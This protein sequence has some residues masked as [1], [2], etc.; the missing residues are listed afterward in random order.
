MTENAAKEAVSFKTFYCDGHVITSPNADLPNIV[1]P[2]AMS[3]MFS[4][5]PFP[6]ECRELQFSSNAYPWLGFVPS[7]PRWQG[8]LLGK[9]AYNKH[10]IRSLVEWR[11]HTHFLKDEIYEEWHQLEI[12]LIHVTNELI[13]FSGVALP[14]Q[15]ALFPLPSYYKYREGHLGQ[16]K[17]VK[18]IMLAR[19]A[20]I[21]LTSLCSFAIAMTRE[22][23]S[24]N[25]P[26]AQWLIDQGCHSSFV[27][28]LQDSQIADFSEDRVGVFIK[29]GWDFQPYTD[30]FVSAGVPVWLLWSNKT[31]FTHHRTKIYYP[32]DEAVANA[33]QNPHPAK[34][35]VPSVLFHTALPAS[36]DD[37][38]PF[39]PL[40]KLSRQLV[41]ETFEEYFLRQARI[42]EEKLAVETPD[43]NTRRL[44]RERAQARH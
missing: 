44:N 9:L 23:R 14:L 11:K 18:S 12:A 36:A 2:D 24:K 6:G 22:F 15:W 7:T 33:R 5:T 27:E 38:Q 26:W 8:R 30:R 17:F 25:P 42:R 4:D 19:D 20:F 16:D 28:E 40:P 31:S 39:P 32:S 21:P 3:H 13:A 41:G 10:T 37:L 29:A 35:E 34:P 43:N 1:D